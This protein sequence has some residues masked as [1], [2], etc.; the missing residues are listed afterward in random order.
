MKKVIRK[1]VLSLFMFF[2]TFVVV[3]AD[4]LY[5][6][7][8]SG[9]IIIGN[10]TFRSGTWVSTT[11]ASKAGALFNQ[12]TG[13]TNLKTY[14]YVNKNLW[15][16]LNDAT[17]EYRMLS[18]SEI[19]EI[20]NNLKI[21]YEN[22]T[23]LIHTYKVDSQNFYG[24]RVTEISSKNVTFDTNYENVTCPYGEKFEVSF[25]VLPA[26]DNKYEYYDAYC[27]LDNVFYF[28]N[29]DKGYYGLNILEVNKSGGTN[30]DD[31]VFN[32]VYNN[33]D[34]DNN[35][36]IQ[37]SV[38]DNLKDAPDGYT[39]GKGKF[40]G[41]NIE[42]DDNFDGNSDRLSYS[43]GGKYYHLYSTSNV[44]YTLYDYEDGSLYT[45]FLDLSSFD[46]KANFIITDDFGNYQTF[47]IKYKLFNQNNYIEFDGEKV[48]LYELRNTVEYSDS[49][50]Y[51]EPKKIDYMNEYFGNLYFDK[52]NKK[53][54]YSNDFVSKNYS[55]D[56][57]DGKSVRNIHSYSKNVTNNELI[58]IPVSSDH[59]YSSSLY[60]NDGSFINFKDG[61]SLF[62]SF[63]GYD[64]FVYYFKKYEDM[65]SSEQEE[66]D[67]LKN[68]DNVTLV[69]YS[70][71]FNEN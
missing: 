20:E 65:D 29:K 4:S 66:M 47:T 36:E 23:P 71:Y 34:D 68:L 59:F 37:V 33:L 62:N 32:N 35:F 27:G 41:L 43:K 12:N 63:K 22:N 42:F 13:S 9:D 3:N 28:N 25:L 31:N 55:L 1:I 16:E 46:E 54:Y 49:Q 67:Y 17:D 58:A 69:D 14:F 11:R 24:K 7:L 52:Y 64:L 40:I 30:N 51:Y 6:N 44:N 10:T 56:F 45:L 21:F 57:Y 26:G 70:N 8:Q 60:A 38:L 50:R 61:N 2:C 39:Y 53:L 19:S 5:D 15:Y 18:S 48:E